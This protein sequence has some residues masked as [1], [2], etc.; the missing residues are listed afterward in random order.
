MVIAKE[1]KFNECGELSQCSTMFTPKAIIQ[2]KREFECVI[3]DKLSFIVINST[4]DQIV[5]AAANH[6]I[7]GEGFYEID[8][9]PIE[10]DHE[11]Y[12]I[13]SELRAMHLF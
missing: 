12:S 8:G 2:H 5:T 9:N 1:Y 10:Y 6:S 4:L 11:G 13:R 7:I 3:T